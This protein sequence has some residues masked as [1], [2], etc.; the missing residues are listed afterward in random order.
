MVPCARGRPGR[1]GPLQRGRR[2]G[3]AAAD[4]AVTTDWTP[5]RLAQAS[6]AEIAAG[7][8]PLSA[9]WRIAA[10]R[11]AAAQGRAAF[12]SGL[13]V[14]EFAA[15]R[16]VGFTPV[17][18]VMGS[19]VYNIGWSYTGCGYMGGMWTGYAP[20]AVVDVPATRQ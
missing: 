4:R 13:S 17:G 3:V 7:R 10:Q 12:T 18:Q 14:D 16:T 1:A 15:L 2:G 6:T 11:E 5:E 20:A 9:Q 19:A 8:L